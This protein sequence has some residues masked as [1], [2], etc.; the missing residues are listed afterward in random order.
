MTHPSPNPDSFLVDVGLF[1]PRPRHL[2]HVFGLD[3]AESA[4][5]SRAELAPVVT[6]PARVDADYDVVEG[7]CEVVLEVALELVRDDLAIRSAVPAD[8][9]KTSSNG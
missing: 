5:H 7:G 1:R 2:G 3:L 8:T 4:A 9:T 6:G